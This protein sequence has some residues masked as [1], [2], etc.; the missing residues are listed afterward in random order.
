MLYLSRGFGLAGER[1][2]QN[3]TLNPGRFRPH[4]RFPK[5]N[6]LRQKHKN[7]KYKRIGE[8]DSSLARAEMK[9]KE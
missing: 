5:Y 2:K 4:H 1:V 8:G 6:K 7:I 3:I 9:T